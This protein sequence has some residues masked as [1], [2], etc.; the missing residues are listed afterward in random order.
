[1]TLGS[2]HANGVRAPCS[3]LLANVPSGVSALLGLSG[4][5]PVQFDAP[6]KEL[7]ENLPD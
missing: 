3:V 2:I 7:V 4:L 6:I 5:R 1:M